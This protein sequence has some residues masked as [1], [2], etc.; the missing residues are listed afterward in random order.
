MDKEPSAEALIREADQYLY[1]AKKEGRNK[2]NGR[3]K[4]NEQ[5][6]VI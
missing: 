1:Q 6:Q 2:V 4:D 5:R 3:V